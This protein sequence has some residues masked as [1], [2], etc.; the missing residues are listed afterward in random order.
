MKLDFNA[1]F[2]LGPFRENWIQRPTLPCEPLLTIIQAGQLQFAEDFVWSKNR[3]L[4]HPC[5]DRVLYDNPD[6]SFLQC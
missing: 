3:S 2:I 4:T 1:V 6:W 5:G